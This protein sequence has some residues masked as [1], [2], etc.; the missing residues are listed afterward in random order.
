MMKVIVFLEPS[1]GLTQDQ[2]EVKI[3][4]DCL[5]FVQMIQEFPFVSDPAIFVE[6]R[7]QLGKH[8]LGGNEIG[9][10]ANGTE[11]EFLNLSNPFASNAIA[12]TNGLQ[13]FSLSPFK[14]VTSTHNI[15]GPLRQRRQKRLA[16]QFGPKSNCFF[17]HRLYLPP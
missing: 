8:F 15:L 4:L 9:R 14:T 2:Q 17:S 10:L 7:F 3:I 11:R 5:I 12:L 16:N 6:R 1:K 13:C